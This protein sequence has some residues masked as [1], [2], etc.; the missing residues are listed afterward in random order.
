[1]H[2]GLLV[3]QFLSDVIQILNVNF[4]PYVFVSEK[5]L[6]QESKFIST[7]EDPIIKSC[8]NSVKTYGAVTFIIYNN[9]S[10]TILFRRAELDRR[11]VLDKRTNEQAILFHLTCLGR[12]IWF[13]PS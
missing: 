13:L 6:C 10:P 7:K 9:K 4:P 1:M 5:S 11:A 3:K 12:L 8:L 2:T